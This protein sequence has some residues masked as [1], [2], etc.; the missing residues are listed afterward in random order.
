MSSDDCELS[1][2]TEI[3]EVLTNLR[4]LVR[5]RRRR[6]RISMRR[7][8]EIT[9]LAG[10][11]IHRFEHGKDVSTEGLLALVRWVGDLSPDKIPRS[12]R[13]T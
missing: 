11:S 2:Y 10:S 5:E 1:T 8:A 6:E 13:D 3:V 7:L 4:F 9:G 12:G